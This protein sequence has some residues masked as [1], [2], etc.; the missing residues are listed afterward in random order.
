MDELINEMY[1]TNADFKVYVDKYLK[2]HE[3]D[4]ETALTHQMVKNYAAYLKDRGEME[5]VLP[6]LWKNDEDK[7]Y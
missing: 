4:L 7:G 2:K 1:S 6:N 3:I 5:Q